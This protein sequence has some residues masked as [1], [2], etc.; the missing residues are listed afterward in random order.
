MN[1]HLQSMKNIIEGI[2]SGKINVSTNNNSIKL[3]N[4]DLNRKPGR[5]KNSDEVEFLEEIPQY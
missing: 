4:K 5:P 2:S 1:Y 3:T